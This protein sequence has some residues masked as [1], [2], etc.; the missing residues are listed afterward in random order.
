MDAL[1]IILG[2]LTLLIAGSVAL[3]RLTRP[4]WPQVTVSRVICSPSPAWRE[5]APRTLRLLLSRRL[6][7]PVGG[8]LTVEFGSPWTL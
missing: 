6:T 2:G 4:H 1:L 8:S 3:A 5:V 7:M